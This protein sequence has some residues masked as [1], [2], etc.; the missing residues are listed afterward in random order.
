MN[1]RDA[2]PL[3]EAKNLTL[4]RGK[5]RIWEN[6]HWTIQ[7]Y[8]TI[9]GANGSGKSSTLALLAGQI[10]PDAGELSFHCQNA[11]VTP[12]QWMTHVVLSAPWASVPTHLTLTQILSFH[13]TFRA[14][15]EDALGWASLLESSGL[16]VSPNAPMH[17]WSSGQKQRLHLSLALGT[18]SPVVLLDEP[19]SNLD[20][21]GV[22]WLH[23]AMTKITGLS[24]LIV[25]TNDPAKEAP[26]ATG[27]FQL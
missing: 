3:F 17:T 20:A 6:G 9:L 21:S 10:A 7:G 13:S 12:E 24:T 14:S 15:R 1:S 19:S 16:D 27:T 5:R 23:S 22:D 8:T 26:G 18:H 4:H 11:A 2:L 25:A